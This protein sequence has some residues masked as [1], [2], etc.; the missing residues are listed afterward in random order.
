LRFLLIGKAPCEKMTQACQT[1]SVTDEAFEN[2]DS[3]TTSMCVPQAVAMAVVWANSK[4]GAATH[5][6][7]G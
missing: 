5:P 6:H 1:N 4:E 7:I 2:T 3:Y